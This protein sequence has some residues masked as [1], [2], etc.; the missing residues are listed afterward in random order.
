MERSAGAVRAVGNSLQ[1][2][3][4]LV[5][6]RDLGDAP[7][8]DSGCR[9]RCGPNRLGRIGGLDSGTS[10]P[11]RCRRE[12]GTAGRVASKGECSRD[13][14]GRSGTAETRRPAGG[15]GQIGE[16]LGRSRGGFTTRIH[17]AADG[18]C[19]PLAFVLTPGH[20]GDGPQ[21]ERVLEEVSV[22]RNGVGRPRTRP[23]RVLADKAYTSRSNRRYLR[24]RGIPHTIPERLDQQRHRKNRGSQGGRPTSFDNERYKKRNTVER[25][26][27][28]LK[29]FRAVATRYEKRAYIYLG[30]VTLAALAIWLRT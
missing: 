12:E 9:G 16:C 5:G 28:R 13:E 8:A 22:P 18:R 7:V 19:R 10:P 20:Y 11:A 15:G 25:T 1:A 6:R 2:A 24:R 27:N 30:T 23:G 29:G 14:P 4:P 26:I 21:L 17:L 3:S